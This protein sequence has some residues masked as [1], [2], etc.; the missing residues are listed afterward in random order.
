MGANKPIRENRH[1]LFYYVALTGRAGTDWVSA[2]RSHQAM[3]LTRLSE[4]SVQLMRRGRLDEA[5]SKLRRVAEHR[6]AVADGSP[7][8][9]AVLDRFYLGAQAY[10]V[11]SRGDLETADVLIT[12]SSSAIERSIQ[13]CPFLF[14]FAHQCVELR[15]QRARIARNRQRW[16]E[17][18]DHAD[19][20]QGMAEGTAPLCFLA[21]GSRLDYDEMARLYRNDCGV[22]PE[23]PALQGMLDPDH[24]RR[25]LYETL[26]FIYAFNE[27]VIRYP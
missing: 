11:Y 13:L 7:V 21:D 6:Q 24:R 19:A 22:D 23:D 12:R 14:P 4:A 17:M 9:G 1:G 16:N 27:T 20:C 25:V 5:E 15:L 2:Y 10:L 26:R 3:D 18:S 8:H